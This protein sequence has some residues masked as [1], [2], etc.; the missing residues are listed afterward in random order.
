[1]TKYIDQL[2]S[3]EPLKRRREEADK[4][5]GRVID[6]LSAQEKLFQDRK[7]A[8]YLVG[9]LGRG[10]VGKSSDL[11]LFL[12]TKKKESERKWLED[13]EILS[14]VVQINVKSWIWTIQ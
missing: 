8:A 1:M 14:S 11:D 7:V 4:A 13:I 5:C 6:K 2:L 9:S 12:I 10:D 3:Y